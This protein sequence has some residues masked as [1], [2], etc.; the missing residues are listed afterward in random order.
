MRLLSVK[1]LSEGGFRSLTQ[2][3]LY[4]FEESIESNRLSTKVFAGVNGSGKSNFLELLSDIFYYLEVYCL[5][6]VDQSKKKKEKAQDA[7]KVD[8]IGFEI[9]Y[10]LPRPT[11]ILDDDYY[12]DINNNDYIHVRIAK[13]IGEDPEFS[14]Y[15]EIANKRIDKNIHLLLPKRIIAYTSGQNELLSNSYMKLRH[16]YFE[17]FQK[18]NHCVT[19]ADK[20]RLIYL[21]HS[22][23][24]IVF[25]AN[26]LLGDKNKIEY[27]SNILKIKNLHSFRITLNE[28]DIDN[29]PVKFIGELEEYRDKLKKCATTWILKQEKNRLFYI[30]DF[31][32]TDATME[33]FS[34]HFGSAF[35]LFKAFYDLEM[36]NLYLIKKGDRR[37]ISKVHKSFNFTDDLAKHNPFRLIFR[38]ENIMLEKKIIGEEDPV[39]IKYKS[40]SDGE[41]QFNE[42]IG[43][44]LMMEEDGC[45]FL[46]DEP[47]THFNPQWRAKMVEII[48]YVSATNYTSDKIPTK[49]KKQEII[50]TTHS[51]F[52]VSDTQ[53]EDVYIFERKDNET[54][55]KKPEVETYGA[56]INLI[57]QEVFDRSNSISDYANN[58]ME[59]LKKE[60]LKATSKGELLKLR[61]EVF[62]FGE[63]F[64]KFDLYNLLSIK[65]KEIMR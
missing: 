21:D 26:M 53:R 37:L 28:V 55:Y 58:A 32:I 61:Q 24:H 52:I 1:I 5:A 34:Y 51:P 65:E 46:L 39:L 17:Q 64:E 35:N 27:V 45:L 31:H 43:S 49:V 54:S 41:H 6:L 60:I 36:Q 10:L 47:D 11:E 14:I 19:S 63:S 18:Q 16:R 9:E 3:K 57:L 56:S 20:H 62:D 12:I 50:L 15:N 30:F 42:I 48:N 23:N 29:K 2:N 22:I 13:P 38:I 40:L 8:N 44:I 59:E 25:I 33:A 4:S 7:K